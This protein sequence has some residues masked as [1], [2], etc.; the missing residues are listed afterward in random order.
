LTEETRDHIERCWRG[1]L[2]LAST[3]QSLRNRC[4]G[5]TVTTEDIRN[6]FARLSH[7]YG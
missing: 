5:Q 6:E 4:P 7:A 1:G 3:R 2:S